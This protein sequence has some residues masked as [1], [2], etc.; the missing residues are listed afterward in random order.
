MKSLITSATF[1]LAL[2]VSSPALA[3]DYVIDTK[4]AHASVNFKIQHLGY[5]WLV[6]RFDQFGG[7]FSFDAADPENSKIE[8]TIDT[9]S[10]NTNHAERDNHLRG[11]DFLDAGKFPQATFVSTGIKKTGEKT[12]MIT[13]DLSLRGVTKS[14][15]IDAEHIGGGKDPWG[16]FRQGFAG[17]TEFALADFGI[18][19]NLGPASKNVQMTLHVE[20][21]KQ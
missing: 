16:G 9:T 12:A 3:D 5:S 17:T 21:I 6:G 19:F 15:V 1:A 13:G 10:V 11:A 14:V 20:G 4:G 7:T 8:V 2:A 18:D